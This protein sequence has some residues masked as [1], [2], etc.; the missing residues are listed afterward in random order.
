MAVLV[1]RGHA[2]IVLEAIGQLVT[3]QLDLSVSI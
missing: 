2:S 1:T 3:C